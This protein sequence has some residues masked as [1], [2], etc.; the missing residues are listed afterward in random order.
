M[1]KADNNK[2]IIT[3]KKNDLNEIPSPSQTNKQ[4]KIRKDGKGNLI[5][6]KVYPNKKTNY[7]AY[8]IDSLI[9]GKEIASI[10]E[11]ESYK[12]YNL[13]DEEV[14]EDENNEQKIEDANIVKI[15]GCCLIFQEK[16]IKLKRNEKKIVKLKNIDIL[17]YNFYEKK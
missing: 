15:H 10:I 3:D 1:K 9:P 12:K 2:D 13:E 11:I 16:F 4:K 8:L 6:K 17:I 5:L 14:E 7:H